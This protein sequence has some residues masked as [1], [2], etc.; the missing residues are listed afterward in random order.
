MPFSSLISFRKEV[1]SMALACRDA[2]TTSFP[3][4]AMKPNSVMERA[5]YFCPLSV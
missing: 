1:I 5:A 3:F 2:S 4:R